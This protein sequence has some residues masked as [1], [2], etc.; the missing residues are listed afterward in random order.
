MTEWA[1]Y[2]GVKHIQARP[3]V[4]DG[5]EGMEVKYA[6]GYT[7]WSPMAAFPYIK[8]P[9]AEFAESLNTVAS[10]LIRNKINEFEYDSCEVITNTTTADIS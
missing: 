9:N 10:A 1:H 6:D 4:R 8:A 2:V 7:S 5:V 3:M